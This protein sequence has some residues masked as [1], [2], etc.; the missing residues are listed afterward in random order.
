[1]IKQKTLDQKTHIL[2]F[3]KA[4]LDKRLIKNPHNVRVFDLV[5]TKRS[6]VCQGRDSNE[7]P[8]GIASSLRSSQF[9]ERFLRH[10][11]NK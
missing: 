11:P 9:G 2:K 1:M 4:K 3:W 6:E 5:Y 10:T 8:E 7:L